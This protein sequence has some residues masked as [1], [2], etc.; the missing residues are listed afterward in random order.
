M[1]TKM[2][3][4]ELTDILIEN[5]KAL[6]LTPLFESY[7]EELKNDFETI[8][9]QTDDFENILLNFIEDL[10]SQVDNA[11]KR[12]SNDELIFSSEGEDEW[13]DVEHSF[14]IF[15]TLNYYKEALYKLLT[16]V[17]RQNI[18]NVLK[19]LENSETKINNWL[20][21]SSC[22]PLRLT[23]FNK[24]R[25]SHLSIIP[26]DNQF[27]FPWYY[28][29]ADYDEDTINLLV[30]NFEIFLKEGV[31]VREEIKPNL[32]EIIYELKRDDELR[33]ALRKEFVLHETLTEEINKRSSIR[34]LNSCKDAASNY[35]ISEHIKK[36]GLVR[37]T[38]NVIEEVMNSFMDQSAKT[39]WLFISAFCGPGLKDVQRFELFEQVENLMKTIDTIEVK[40]KKEKTL[41]D[42]ARWYKGQLP[43]EW[44]VNNVFNYWIEILE[45]R[46][47][48][49][50]ETDEDIE[51]EEFWNTLM[52]LSKHHAFPDQL[53][54]LVNKIYEWKE[55]KKGESKVVFEVAYQEHRGVREVGNTEIRFKNN[56]MHLTL[57]PDNEGEYFLLPPDT[58]VKS[59]SDIG[60]YKNFWKEFDDLK[61]FWGGLF[62][63]IGK[64]QTE[65]VPSTKITKKFFKEGIIIGKYSGAVIGISDNKDHLKQFLDG[66]KKESGQELKENS[67]DRVIIF[68]I[69]FD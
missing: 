9:N 11:I 1:E 60:E 47:A 68:I 33:S 15:D 57:M 50:S 12:L 53:K 48:N 40:G 63:G 54:Q 61:L 20:Y 42:L 52:N 67:L 35:I 66:L 22:S 28:L 21:D 56:P 38:N 5:G 8:K 36:V 65:L 18:S 34:I 17:E 44:L 37:I 26:E 59:C 4:N 32:Y 30:D 43:D 64:E 62:V 45:S 10:S 31:P 29:F 16:L 25:N 27:L 7:L 13:L 69:S 46:A 51:P 39:F 3:N 41:Y 24:F 23:I 6:I 55:Q 49:M 14:Y 58:L 19:K 2:I